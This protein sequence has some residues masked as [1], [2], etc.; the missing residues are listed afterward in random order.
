MFYYISYTKWVKQKTTSFYGNGFL[1][2]LLGIEPS[3][4][5]PHGRVLPVYYTPS[6][7]LVASTQFALQ[8]CYARHA[9][10]LKIKHV[11]GFAC[12]SCFIS[13]FKAQFIIDRTKCHFKPLYSIIM[14]LVQ[15][16][17]MRNKVPIFWPRIDMPIKK[18]FVRQ[19]V[20]QNRG[21]ELIFLTPD[22]KPIE[23]S[24]IL[25]ELEEE[26]VPARI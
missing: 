18:D 17:Q 12:A 15:G 8:I 2:G 7:K 9:S 16:G 19:G 13:L 20:Q 1:V 11:L 14:I 5:P 25:R 22:G 6:S 10:P 4:H 24:E 26:N 23:V 3:L 21:V